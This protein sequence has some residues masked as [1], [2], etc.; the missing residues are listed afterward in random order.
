MSIDAL[1]AKV[2]L[3]R[4]LQQQADD[5]AAQIESIK[6]IIKGE[7][8]ERSTEELTGPGWRAT[9]KNVKSTRLDTKALK[10][11]E[12][13]TYARYSRETVQTRFSVK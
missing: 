5:I 6:D 8:Y 9:W 7:M 13:E 3:L 4:E 12:P 10:A 1:T 2:T 11:A